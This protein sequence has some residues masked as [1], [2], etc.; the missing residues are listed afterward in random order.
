MTY[1]SLHDIYVLRTYISCRVGMLLSISDAVSDWLINSYNKGAINRGRL[2]EEIFSLYS[3]KEYNGKKINI[4]KQGPA[5]NKE[6]Y[7]C[8]NKLIDAGLV[9]SEKGKELYHSAYFLINPLAKKMSPNELACA[10][11]PYGYISYLSAMHWYGITDRLP[12]VIYFTTCKRNEWSSTAYAQIIDR[13]S[14]PSYARH[15]L[16]IFPK[17]GLFTGR[18]LVISS[19]IHFIQPKEAENGIR[20]QD[21]GDLFLDML[22]EPDRCGGIDHVIDVFMEH[23]TSFRK[24]IIDRTNIHGSDIDKARMG[25][26]LNTVLGIDSPIIEKWKEEASNKRGGSRK[27][28]SNA[29]FDSIFSVDWSISINYERLYKYGTHY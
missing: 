5:T 29:K 1:T 2:Y 9:E 21:I 19:V 8:I 16:P 10:A 26:L 7:A 24:K 23:A 3:L 12:K 15:F 20:I 25:F 6:Y 28:V 14:S 4:R 18:K 27:L 11:Y 17:S 22:R 13:I